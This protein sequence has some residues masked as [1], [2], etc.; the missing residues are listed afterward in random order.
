MNRIALGLLLGVGFGLLSVALMVPMSFPDTRLALAGAFL[1][2]FAIGF[3]TAQVGMPAPHWV[4]GVVVGLLV[5][6]RSAVLTKAFVPIV[7][8]GV[9]GGAICGLISGAWGR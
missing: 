2:R 4:R 7:V 6:L 5:S 1:D 9:I 8:V 3:L